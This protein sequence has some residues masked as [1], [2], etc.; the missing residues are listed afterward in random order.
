[1]KT[2]I[3]GSDHAGYEYKAALIQALQEKHYQVIDVGTYT[4]A[5]CDYPDYAHKVAEMV[6]NNQNTLGILLCG[7]GNGVAITANKHINIRAAVCWKKE[8][9]A[10]A[11]QHNNANILCLPARFISE[12]EALEITEIFLTSTFEGERHQRRVEK[13]NTQLKIN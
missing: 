11:K 9:A 5:S 6:N 1:M 7:T 12:S 8:I 13:I 4:P 3:I 10:L 2:I